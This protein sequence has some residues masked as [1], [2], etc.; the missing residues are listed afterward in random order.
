MVMAGF[1]FD[2]SSVPKLS[3]RGD[4]FAKWRSAYTIVFKFLGLDDY[5]NG[6]KPM[7]LP[8]SPDKPE[9]ESNDNKAMLMLM[10]GVH[11]ELV[12]LVTANP[13]SS[14]AWTALRDHFNRDTGNST[15]YLFR[16]ITS[17]RYKDGEDL[18]THLDLFH[19]LWTK[20]LQRCQNSQ[21]PVAKSM[22]P[23]FDNDN[24]KGSFFLTTLPNTMDGII[25]NLSTKGIDTFSSIEPRMLN[26]AAR[27]NLKEI[28]LAAYYTATSGKGKQRQQGNAKTT[29]K[30]NECTWCKKHDM[31][32]IGHVYTN[33]NKLAKHKAEAKN[34]P[35]QN[36]G[37]ASYSR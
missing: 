10:S 18:G 9:W 14:K 29:D 24:V 35:K 3:S 4:N 1:K 8:A 16:T 12:P 37:A 6:L 5:V 2:P 33:C 15:I 21:Q 32:F 31:T 7:P 30:T 19:Q 27:N 34:K 13:T 11:H 20:M 28:D 25:D 36:Q 17:L 26:I 23:L 22:L